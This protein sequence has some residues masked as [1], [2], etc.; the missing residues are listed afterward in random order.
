MTFLWRTILNFTVVVTLATTINSCSNIPK[1]V[2]N[3]KKMQA[4]MTDMQLAEEMATLDQTTFRSN[5]AKTALYQSVFRKH[6]VTEAEYDSS[7]VWYGKNLERYMQIYKAA[8]DDIQQRILA[9]GDVPP[10]SV[11]E[12]NSDSLDIWLFRRYYDFEPVALTNLVAFDVKPA[13]AYSSGSAF[14]FALEISGLPNQIPVP[15]NVHISTVSDDS[16]FTAMR[17]ITE[18]GY[19]EITLKT[20]VLK[21]TQRVYGYIRLDAGFR[22][23]H[24]IYIDKVSMI[25]YRYGSPAIAA[26]E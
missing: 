16:T 18:N 5:E 14:V 1:G 8:S 7:I 13:V 24:K 19:Y 22:N 12:S 10:E 21:K 6:N 23:Y 3:E 20:N 9:L 25:K 4:V 26:M 17:D 2:L 15:V 11:S